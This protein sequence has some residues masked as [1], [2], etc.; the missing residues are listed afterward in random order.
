MSLF[1]VVIIVVI[2]LWCC[3]SGDILENKP[4]YIQITSYEDKSSNDFNSIQDSDYQD[5]EKRMSEE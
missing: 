5:T 4:Y 2:D 1:F 3:V